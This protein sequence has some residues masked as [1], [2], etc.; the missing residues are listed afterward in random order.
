MNAPTTTE[1]RNLHPLEIRILRLVAERYR[2]NGT[3]PLVDTPLLVAELGYNVGQ[4]NQ[5]TSWLLAKG[6]LE[7]EGRTQR[8]FYELTER[9]EEYRTKGTPE[10]RILDLLSE[11]SALTLPEIAAAL[12]L[13]NRDSG[14][15]FGQMAKEGLV[16]MDDE[17][18]VTAKTGDPSARLR[19]MRALLDRAGSS[20]AL[21]EGA[22]SDVERQVM[23]DISKKRGSAT[24]PFRTAEREEVRYRVTAQGLE[25]A[26]ALI[27]AGLTG[28]EVGSLTPEMIADGSWKRQ[29]FRRYSMSSP[30]SR[31]PLGRR[32]PY[33]EFIQWVKDKLVSLGFEEF[34]GPLVETEF[35]NGATSTTSTTSRSPSAR[36]RS[37][38]PGSTASRPPTRTAATPAARGGATGS[39]GT[40]RASSFC[41][42]RE[43]CSQR[44]SCRRPRSPASI[45]GSSA[46]SATTRSMPRTGPTSTRPKG[47]CSAKA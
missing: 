6:L 38:S 41:E 46:V 1:S 26:R 34:D 39:T 29:T 5:A 35:W 33:G 22:L 44:S 10:E 31:L 18:R 7:E 19:T 3:P 23:G 8:T 47:S 17:K 21:E 24:A 11:K 27:D 16:G 12:G 45:S 14:S 30:P 25:A 37:S 28:E 42:V 9:G 20:G 15:A 2:K 36:G 13:D 32:N 43:R 4:C 40:S